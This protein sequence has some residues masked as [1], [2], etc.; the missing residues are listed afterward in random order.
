[1]Y[2]PAST[3][4]LSVRIPKGKIA[5][6]AEDEEDR[7]SQGICQY[8]TSFLGD[9]LSAVSFQHSA[10]TVWRYVLAISI[11]GCPDIVVATGRLP[12]LNRGTVLFWR[13]GPKPAPSSA[14]GQYPGPSAYPQD[15]MRQD[16][17]SS[18]L[19]WNPATAA[20]AATRPPIS[21]VS[22][23][24]KDGWVRPATPATFTVRTPPDL[25][26]I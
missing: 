11:R 15:S 4:A 16:F 24:S 2:V 19:E 10:K 14:I 9:Q 3:P 8:Q 26:W 21:A 6:H 18:D 25:R 7:F 12:R 1:M 20:S 5:Y 22:G 17:L 23:T 13:V